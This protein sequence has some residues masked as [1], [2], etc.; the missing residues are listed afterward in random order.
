[1]GS[2]FLGLQEGQF[3]YAIIIKLQFLI[4][5]NFTIPPITLH[6]KWVNYNL[7]GRNNRLPF[8]NTY[9]EAATLFLQS[10][11]NGQSAIPSVT[12]NFKNLPVSFS[13][14]SPVRVVVNDRSASS[15]IS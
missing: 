15:C 8:S 9:W 13:V 7:E 12:T 1:M 5:L 10:C 3:D 14:F 4:K 6:L 11:K 2:S